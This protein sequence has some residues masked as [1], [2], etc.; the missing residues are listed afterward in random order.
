M[1]TRIIGI[2]LAVTAA[3]QAIVLDPARKE[4]LGNPRSFRSNP[5]DLSKIWQ[6]AHQGTS[7]PVEVVVICEAT[8]M[9]WYPVC[10][11]FHRLGAKV[12][13]VHGGKTRDMRQ[14]L[15]RHAGSDRIDC[16]ALAK[17]YTVAQEH[18]V[19]WHLATGAQLALQRACREA[20]G[21]REEDVARQNRIA[22]YDQWTWGGLSKL[23]PAQAQDWMHQH[24][25][26][27]W[28]VQKAGR[29][30]LCAAWQEA[31]PQQPADVDW[32]PGWLTRA[33]EM[34]ALYA[35]PELV[36][37]AELQARMQRELTLRAQ[38]QQAHKDLSRQHILPLYQ[39]LYPDCLLESIKGIG[40]DSAALY[41]AFIQDIA[42]FPSI[43]RFRSW[44]GMIPGSHQSGDFEAKHMPLTQAGP[45][46]VK[47]T[48][49]LNANVA[50]QWDVQLAAL[51]H[52]QMVQ[53]GKHHTQ[54][55]CACAS[56][57]ANRIYAVLTRQEPYELRDLL[58]RP[59]SGEASRHLCLTEYQVPEDVRQRTRVRARK[60]R[61]QQR[62]E[63]RFEKQAV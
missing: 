52:R 31:A 16:R 49:Y 23:I 18:L 63:K 44:C 14:V 17:L 51:Y 54:A 10:V 45:N 38:A 7:E 39:Q 8:G 5:A 26:D 30:T 27:P 11:Y 55:V 57:L 3:H 24:W 12:L 28:E 13:R 1:H 4:Y 47:A 32:I 60:A 56:H 50:R 19:P 36:G 29:E 43:A 53:Y 58:Q 6:W 20:Y 59:I 21:W 15:Q 34:V 42:R 61:T 48:L 2:D 33:E 9:A 25:Y 22:A 35:S 62:A 40:A 46:L 41:M 37:Y